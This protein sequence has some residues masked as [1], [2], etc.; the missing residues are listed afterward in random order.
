MTADSVI[1]ELSR[2]A[3][4]LV[5]LKPRLADQGVPESIVNLPAIGFGFLNDKLKKWD[6]I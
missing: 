5:D 4:Q 3:T 2:L 6:L 1:E